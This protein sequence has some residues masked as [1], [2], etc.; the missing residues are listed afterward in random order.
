MTIEVKKTASTARAAN[1]NVP[2][3]K[4]SPDPAV[5]ADVQ[6]LE[7]MIV[8]RLTGELK[9]N[10]RNARKHPAKQIKQLQASINAFGFTVPILTD[11]QGMILA[12]HGR[13]GPR[14][15]LA[16]PTYQR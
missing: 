11:E 7:P 9:P 12:G 4:A 15:A 2:P 5:Q 1:E 16:W 10:P 8:M 6:A 13:W 14:E 3:V